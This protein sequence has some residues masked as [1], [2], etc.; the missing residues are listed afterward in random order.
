MALHLQAVFCHCGKAKMSVDSVRNVIFLWLE[1][2]RL[3][4][5][6]DQ[7]SRDSGPELFET[8]TTESAPGKQGGMLSLVW[9]MNAQVRIFR[10]ILVAAVY[11]SPSDNR[12]PNAPPALRHT[13]SVGEVE[14]TMSG[15]IQTVAMMITFGKSNN[16]SL[17]IRIVAYL[18]SRNKKPISCQ[19]V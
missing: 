8:H 1:T 6:P 15:L 7:I 18:P 4:G 16:N 3:F 10:K 19:L 9:N 11:N 5:V 12:R 17:E 2:P 14:Q 13:Q